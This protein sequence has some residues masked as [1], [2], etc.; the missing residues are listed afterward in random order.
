MLFEIVQ[1]SDDCTERAGLLHTSHGVIETP[2][3]MPVGTQATVKAIPQRE[4]IEIGSQ[5]ILGNTYHLY[6]RPGME[7]IEKFGGLH[8]FMNWQKPILTDSGGFQIFSLS[9]LRKVTDIGVEFKSHIDGSYHFFDPAKVIEIQRTIGSDIMMVLDEC[10]PN[11]SDYSKVK[12]SIELT[13]DWAVQAKHSFTHTN[14]RYGYEQFLFAIIQGGTYKDLRKKSA[15]DLIDLDFSGYAIGGLAVGETTEEL[16][17]ITNFTTDLMPLEKPRYL[18]GVGRPENILECI[19]RGIDMFDCVMPTRNGR[20]AYLFTS[21]GIVSIRNN[22]YK[23]DENPID[24]KCDC[25]TCKN[26]S[27]AYIRHLFNAKEILAL[28]LATIHN[29]RFYMNLVTEARNKI[30]EGKFTQWKK[31][32]IEHITFRNNNTNQRENIDSFIYSYGTTSR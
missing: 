23:F 5:I 13:Y 18:M 10:V 11:P 19:E 3:F 30:L 1:K 27:R 17:D 31:E 2:V 22:Q 16:Y 7:V 28:Q 8:K 6:L 20:N 21:D 25:Y 24:F 4:L 9:D 26:F 32:T 15:S 29:L 12:E 14:S